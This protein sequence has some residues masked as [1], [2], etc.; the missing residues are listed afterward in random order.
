MVGEEGRAQVTAGYRQT[1][2]EEANA[3]HPRFFPLSVYGLPHF[4]SKQFLAVMQV[5][6]VVKPPNLWKA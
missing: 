1:T 5:S 6:D 3:N 2:A 4:N